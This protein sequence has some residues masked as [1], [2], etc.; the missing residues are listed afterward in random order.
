MEHN[1][2]HYCGIFGIFGHP[3][4]A[5]LAMLGLNALQ[6]RGEES[7]GIVTGDGQKV[8]VKTGMG[9]VADVFSN[10]E[11]LDRLSGHL[12]IGHN[13]YSTTGADTSFNAQPFV[14]ECRDGYIAVAHNGNLTNAV[15]L[16]RQMQ[17]NGA[18]FQTT[19]DSEIILHLIARSKQAQTAN[20]IAEA[21]QYIQGAYSLVLSTEDKLFIVRDP[22][23]FRPLCLGRLG[24]AWIAASESCA[25]DIISARYIRDI[26]P[27]ELVV[28][29]THGLRTFSPCESVKYSFCIFEHIYFSRPDS[30][31]FGDIVDK[32]R[33]K[34]GK[35]LALEH[36]ADADIVISVPDS[37]NTAA[38]GYSDQSGIKL[39]I[40]L[41]RNHYI[42]RTFITPE[43][44]TRSAKVRIKFN[45]VRNVL[46]GKRVVVVEDSIVR[47]TTLQHL[48]RMIRE[49]GARQ[50]HIRISCPPIISPCFYGIDFQTKKELIANKKT[51][52]QIREHL[53]VDSLGYLSLE[54]MLQTAPNAADH[55]CTACFTQN[56]PIP[57]DTEVNKLILER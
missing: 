32:T 20:R 31:I 43:Q 17:K 21:L 40:G 23:G 34:L 15:Q 36:P 24:D 28:I 37:S 3:E 1:V 7:C 53:G 16:R 22:Y 56:Y 45:P 50:V 38:L 47:G 26:E 41:I 35:Q 11:T 14:A 42:G 18:I 8:F 55:Y 46:K 6:H 5:K 44:D 2:K 27:G 4:A 10:P 49:A 48:V 52:D 39:E 29:D 13:R 9:H 30:I 19:S 33:R 54:G 57:I 51:V 12:A 25:L